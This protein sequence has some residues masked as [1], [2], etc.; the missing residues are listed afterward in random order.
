MAIVRHIRSNILYR[1]L[2]ENKYRN[3]TTLQEGEVPEEKARE[4]FKINIEATSIINEYPE[5]EN[6][7]NKLQLKFEK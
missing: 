3:L 6:L 2:G 7:I 4:I 5:V 1:Y